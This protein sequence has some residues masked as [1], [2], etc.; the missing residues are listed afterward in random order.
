MAMGQTLFDR[1][2]AFQVKIDDIAQ[3][4]TAPTITPRTPATHHF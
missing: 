4:H 2:D 1:Q 3:F